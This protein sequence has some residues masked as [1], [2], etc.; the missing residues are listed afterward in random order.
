MKKK[1]RGLGNPAL[2]A[3]ASSAAQNPVVIQNV[4]K[5][6]RTLFW[7]ILGG[8]GVF[9]GVKAYKNFNKQ[10]IL[11]EVDT[12]Q[13]YRAAQSI[14]AAIPD[15]LKKGD[16]SLF[17]PWG[18]VTDLIN[19]VST[20]W[21]KTNTQRILDIGRTEI[22]NFDETAK[23]FKVL[24]G[25]DLSMLLQKVMNAAEL[26]AFYNNASAYKP[27]SATFETASSG[28]I[29][30]VIVTTKDSSLSTMY[31]T[32][33]NKLSSLVPLSQMVPAGTR[34]GVFYGKKV[35]N[36][37]SGDTNEYYIAKYGTSKSGNTIAIIVPVK[38]SKFVSNIAGSLSS[39][40]KIT[41]QD[42]AK[43]KISVS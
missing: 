33:D 13:N 36:V 4:Q 7:L 16:G 17:N 1:K 25:E 35:T 41:F 40:K 39:Y 5:G 19:Q 30:K 31:S 3:A 43:G 32:A 22:T 27:A 34:I 26:N 12:N 21:E 18:F 24:Y 11:K 38:N 29:G 42:Y 28:D 9:F 37:K 6:T 10:S 8:A 20:I 23:A 14:Y 15:G 2:V